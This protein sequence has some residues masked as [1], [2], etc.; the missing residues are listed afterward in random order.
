MT[1]DGGIDGMNSRTGAYSLNEGNNWMDE[2]PENHHAFT[3]TGVPEPA[4]MLLLS[5]GG[6][7]VLRRRR[8]A[9]TATAHSGEPAAPRPEL[10]GLPTMPPRPPP[11][12]TRLSFDYA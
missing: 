2:G 9:A 6:L 4:S 7:V 1:S 5:L 3:I 8:Q 10:Q 11:P 12:P